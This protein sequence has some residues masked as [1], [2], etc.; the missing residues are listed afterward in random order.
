MV[1]NGA[2]EE[3]QRLKTSARLQCTEFDSAW[4][5]RRQS[6]TWRAAQHGPLLE[7]GAF[8]MQAISIPSFDIVPAMNM[9]T[10]ESGYVERGPNRAF[11]PPSSRR[12]EVRSS[13]RT[14][15]G[16]LRCCTISLKLQKGSTLLRGGNI[17]RSEVKCRVR[18]ISEH[19]VGCRILNRRSTLLCRNVSMHLPPGTASDV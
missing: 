8:G 1:A 3:T 2:E 15:Q 7:S 10:W 19:V 16:P 6:F 11:A 17:F 14:A 13:R 9:P 5:L 18:E 4:G 12:D